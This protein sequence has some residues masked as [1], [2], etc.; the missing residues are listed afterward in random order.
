MSMTDR[1]ILF[2]APMARALLDRCKTQRVLN[3]QPSAE[4]SPVTEDDRVAAIAQA[5]NF[6]AR[7]AAYNMPPSDH[8]SKGS[9]LLVAWFG[10]PY[11][12]V[13]QIEEA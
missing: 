11:A 2:S 6:P 10:P 12:F 4:A 8:V 7:E 9:E 3:P 13:A 5:G 1:P